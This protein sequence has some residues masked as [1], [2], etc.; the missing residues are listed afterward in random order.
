MK[1]VIR[2]QLPEELPVRSLANQ[3]RALTRELP[4]IES[5]KSKDGFDGPGSVRIVLE[6][7]NPKR[8]REA[9]QLMSS[10]LRRAGATSEI[11]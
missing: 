7:P 10:Y 9:A 2:A 4:R 6:D 3:L 5:A 11:D 1:I 8:V